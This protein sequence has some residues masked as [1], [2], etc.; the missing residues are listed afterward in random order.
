MNETY[1]CENF[2]LCDIGDICRH[3][4]PHKQ[5]SHHPRDPKPTWAC[6]LEDY[7]RDTISC[8]CIE[9]ERSKTC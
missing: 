1:I 9:I 5:I 3:G 4:K 7:P 8:S 6:R 2:I